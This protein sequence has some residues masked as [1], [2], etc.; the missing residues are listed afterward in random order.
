MGVSEAAEEELVAVQLY[1]VLVALHYLLSVKVH[2]VAEGRTCHKGVI[3]C[4][5]EKFEVF[6]VEV[7]E[8]L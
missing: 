1:H 5:V 7:D 8:S 6:V 2:H 4:I 3:P